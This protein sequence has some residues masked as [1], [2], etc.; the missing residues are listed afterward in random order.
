MVV[1]SVEVVGAVA[2][3]RCDCVGGEVLWVQSA[4]EEV[5]KGRGLG[6]VCQG[7]DSLKVK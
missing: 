6:G 2:T 4:D 3:S 5:Y 1:R 7:E